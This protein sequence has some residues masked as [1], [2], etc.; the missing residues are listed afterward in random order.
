L[1]GL[2]KEEFLDTVEGKVLGLCEALQGVFVFDG[3]EVFL[4]YDTP[5]YLLIS[6]FEII[7]ASR[8]L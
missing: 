8:L 3:L 5:Y 7:H 1:I 2:L 4:G 6:K